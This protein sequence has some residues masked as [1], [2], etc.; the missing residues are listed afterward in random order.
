MYRSF[1][2]CAAL[3]CVMGPTL[4]AEPL[5]IKDYCTN[6]SGDGQGNKCPNLNYLLVRS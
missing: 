4:S 5:I 2:I 3:L 6:T 1:I